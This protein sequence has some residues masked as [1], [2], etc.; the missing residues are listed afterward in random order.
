MPRSL[1]G[2]LAALAALATIAALAF[3][4]LAIGAVLEHFVMQGLDQRL[5]AQVALLATAVGPDG[6]VDRSRLVSPAPFDRAGSGWGWRID[7]PA[8]SIASADLPRIEQPPPPDLQDHRH[9]RREEGEPRPL[10]WRDAKGGARHARSITV[11]TSAGPVRIAASAPREIVER[12][13]RAAMTPLLGSLALLGL[14]L[15]VATLVQLR[16]GLRPLA[17]LKE[18]LASVRA[19]RAEAVPADQ[20]AELQ[21]LADELNALLAENAAA[22][23]N[24]RGHVANLAH[25]LKTPLAALALRLGEQGSDPDGMMAAEV[26]RMDRSIRHHLGRARAD[27]SGGAARRRTL[28]EPAVDGVAE[29]LAR[30][31]ADRAISFSRSMPAGLALAIDP[32]DLDELLGNLL[33]NGWRWAASRIT[34]SAEPGLAGRVRINIEDDGPGIAAGDRAEALRPGRRLDESGDGHGFGLSIVR[35]LAELYGGA[36]ALEAT[37]SGGLRAI[38]TL[39][40]AATGSS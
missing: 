36:L 10:D 14:A 15:G 2:R 33:D 30:I 34:L 1:F 25:G 29:A 21:P 9:R 39:P 11:R 23:A 8:G 12:P 22:L 24:A 18:S 3:A 4:A 28:L 35:E 37:P 17:L 26:S 13:L 19:G 6:T 38:V 32:Q 5:D 16:L 40:M 7:A 27:A 20:P 31:H